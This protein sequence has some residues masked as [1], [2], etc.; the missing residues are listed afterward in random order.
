[1]LALAGLPLLGA[2]GC[3]PSEPEGPNPFDTLEGDPAAMVEAKAVYRSYCALCH[4]KDGRGIPGMSPTARDLTDP[5]W[6]DSVEEAH[7]RKVIREGGAAVGL[8]PTMT[9][10]DKNRL[11]DDG[12]SAMVELVRSIRRDG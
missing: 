5:A 2:P 8:H 11:S 6:Q 4:A 9:G 7:L 1:M 10:A 12:L 3:S